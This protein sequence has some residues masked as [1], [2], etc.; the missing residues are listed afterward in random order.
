VQVSDRTPVAIKIVKGDINDYTPYIE[1]L[2]QCSSQH[3]VAYRAAY[4]HKN[5][6]WLI[7]EFCDAGSL[8]NL[9]SACDTTLSE[10]MIA[11]ACKHLLLALSELH[12]KGLMHRDVQCSNVLL[13]SSGDVKLGLF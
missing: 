12:A 4:R 7:F 2:Q 5:E 6:H 11:I 1:A 13:H 8:S 9:M 10:D 3:V